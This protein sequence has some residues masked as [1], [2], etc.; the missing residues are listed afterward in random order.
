[1][2]VEKM[3]VDD[4]AAWEEL[5]GILEANPNEVLHDPGSEWHWTSRDIYAHLARW[6]TRSTAE[7]EAAAA[8]L[9]PP[10][11]LEGTEDEIN[12]RWQIED[13][14]LTLAEAR[15]RATGAYE[16]RLHALRSVPEKAWTAELEKIAR[17]DGAEHF[18]AHIGYIVLDRQPHR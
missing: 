8:G 2:N 4:T 17:Y 16:H 12:R 1:M 13:S 7:L 9:D 3:I 11:P 14:G 15:D 5:V 18:R 10:A 6:I